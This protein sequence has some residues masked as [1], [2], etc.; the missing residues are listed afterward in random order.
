GIDCSPVQKG[1]IQPAYTDIG[2]GKIER[3]CA[4]WA[5]RGAPVEM[6]AA[7]ELPAILGTPIF[8]AGWI[9]RRG[10]SINPL[11]YARGLA[12]AAIALG[13]SVHANTAARTLRK[14]GAKW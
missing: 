14:Q 2:A 11:G 6:L 4:Q 13:A 1:W 3:R 7:A 10:G 5:R 9:D 8:Q 12:K